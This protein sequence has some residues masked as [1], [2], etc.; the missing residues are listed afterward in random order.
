M[1]EQE[2]RT[3][4]VHCVAEGR[5]ITTA[6]RLVIELLARTSEHLTADDLATRVHDAHPEIHLST[7]YRTLDS[8]HEWGLVEHVHQPH[9]PSFFHLAGA[10]RHLVCEQCGRIHDVPAAEFD[11]LVEPDTRAVRLRAARRARRAGRALPHPLATST[12]RRGSERSSRLTA[13]GGAYARSVDGRGK[14]FHA[15]LILTAFGF[16]FRHGIDWDHI[17]A[18]TD[19]T[20]SQAHPRR[21]MFLPP[22]TRPDTGS[23]CSRS[24]SPRSSSPRGSRTVSTRRW[25]GR[26]RDADRARGVR[27][28]RG[29][30]PSAARLPHAQSL[31][32]GVR[33]R[34]PR[35]AA[36][37]AAGS[38]A[39]PPRRDRPLSRSPGGPRATTICTCTQTST[40]LPAA[41][42]ATPWAERARIG[43]ASRSMRSGSPRIVTRTGTSGDCPTIRSSTTCA[44]PRSA[45]A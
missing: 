3:L 43:S 20:S 33:G 7:V 38:G 2:T 39:R 15:G 22:S 17:A 14:A 6:R 30:V 32:A 4:D 12:S 42:W 34:A 1:T 31:D 23:S 40:T 11:V 44:V 45:S 36:S 18:L 16:G 13:L 25:S 41:L 19:I 28:L 21:S 27:V 8:L 35:R 37:Y 26:R 10:H 5:R 29:R 24:A 9:G